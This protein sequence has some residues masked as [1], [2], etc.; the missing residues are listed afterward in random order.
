MALAFVCMTKIAMWGFLQ[1]KLTTMSQWAAGVCC[2]PT[3]CR[4]RNCETPQPVLWWTFHGC[5]SASSKSEK[6]DVTDRAFLQLKLVVTSQRS[7]SSRPEVSFGLLNR[8]INVQSFLVFVTPVGQ[9]VYCI[10]SSSHTCPAC[11]HDDGFAST[12][13]QWHANTWQAEVGSITF[14]ELK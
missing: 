10:G 9:R 7:L 5:K 11:S 1:V 14:A 12:R 4:Q 6:I 2:V 13:S 8:T 3:Q